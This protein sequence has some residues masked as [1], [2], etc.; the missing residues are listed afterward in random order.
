MLL[1]YDYDA[2]NTGPWWDH[3]AAGVRMSR[4]DAFGTQRPDRPAAVDHVYSLVA[5][6]RMPSAGVRAEAADS[7][8]T[9]GDSIPA[10]SECWRESS[11]REI[12][13]TLVREY[14]ASRDALT[15]NVVRCGTDWADAYQAED[16]S[17]SIPRSLY[18]SI[19]RGAAR[20]GLDDKC[21]DRTETL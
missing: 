14:E 20:D 10:W 8:E 17:L 19:L 15:G 7:R 4:S 6:T 18:L 1:S 13:L 12:I 11:L 21:S 16:D 3:L 5:Y 2:W 9:A